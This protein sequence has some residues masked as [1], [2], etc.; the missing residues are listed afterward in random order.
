MDMWRQ[1]VWV[2]CLLLGQISESQAAVILKEFFD[3]R[4]AVSSS[5]VYDTTMGNS[6]IQSGQLV[7]SYPVKNEATPGGFSFSLPAVPVDPGERRIELRFLGG[8]AT[9]SQSV[10]ISYAVG[11]GDGLCL[12]SFGWAEGGNV[13][14]TRTGYIVQFQQR[15]DGSAAILLLRNDSGWTNLIQI[16]HPLGVNPTTSLRKLVIRHKRTG[17]HRIDAVFDSGGLFSRTFSFEDDRYPPGN[18]CRGLQISGKGK[19]AVVDETI[20]ILTDSW[21]VEDFPLSHEDMKNIEDDS[22]RSLT[23][24]RSKL[25]SADITTEL[26]MAKQA[27]DSG[28][29]ASAQDA[30]LSILYTDTSN[31][32]ALDLLGLTEN[33]TE[34][35]SD[36]F[37]HF[38]EALE[39]RQRRS[40]PEHGKLAES[41]SHLA[42]MY[43]DRSPSDAEKLYVQS[44]AFLEK[45]YGKDHPRVV[46]GLRD[47][48]RLYSKYNYGR[49][50]QN[51]LTALAIQEHLSGLDNVDL[52]PILND[53]GALYLHR[54][55]RYSDAEKIFRRALA[56]GEN[57]Y[58]TNSREILPVIQQIETIY[59]KQTNY[60]ALEPVYKRLIDL[61]PKF[62]GRHFTYTARRMHNLGMVYF[63]Q[64]RYAEAEEWYKKSIYLWTREIG[65]DHIEI[66]EALANLASVYLKQ[67]K[68][69]DAESCYLRAIAIRGKAFGLDN[70]NL[71]TDYNNLG[72]AYAQQGH[73]R[74]AEETYRRSIAMA[75]K[76]N[77]SAGL[78]NTYVNLAKSLRKLGREMEAIY[79]EAQG[80]KMREK[81]KQ[82]K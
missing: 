30:C 54:Q 63:N 28:D 26:A 57:T 36:A 43:I 52:F 8:G 67:G 77:N 15:G 3:T 16:Y 75:E 4:Q 32:D 45:W 10:Y 58:G 7:I 51:L 11:P 9:L 39:I 27:Y 64:A 14:N 23:E 35:F 37:R 42:D 44:L 55:K 12:P 29:F 68:Y 33:S 1:T 34:Q 25:R 21:I 2:A 71:S 49:A 41:L 80:E 81:E 48:A 6:D 59:E 79:Y 66:S 53:L 24:S 46:E 31:A 38:S 73:D 72:V 56:I 70:P 69:K 40:G 61:V 65:P 76:S 60:A 50:E 5:F 78:A 17:E 74:E 13:K 22:K 18:V 82:G 19:S 47:L 62:G 20:R